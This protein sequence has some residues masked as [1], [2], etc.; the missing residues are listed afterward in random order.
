VAVQRESGA[1][2]KEREK[3]FVVYFR[4]NFSIIVD[5]QFLLQTNI[6]N[7][8]DM[9]RRKVKVYTSRQRSSKRKGVCIVKTCDA[10]RE[11]WRPIYL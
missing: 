2:S 5:H 4:N 7:L 9:R 6:I 10:L 1:L 3:M 11:I 8:I